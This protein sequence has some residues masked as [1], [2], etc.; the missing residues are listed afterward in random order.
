MIHSWPGFIDPPGYWSQQ[1]FKQ[2]RFLG[3]MGDR[4]YP[5]L[6]IRNRVSTTISRFL[7]KILQRNPVSP[8]Q[9]IAPT[10]KQAK[11]LDIIYVLFFS[12]KKG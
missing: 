1:F 8:P 3:H 4:T 9:A 12:K 11:E 10:P 7:A 5:K 6:S 2:N